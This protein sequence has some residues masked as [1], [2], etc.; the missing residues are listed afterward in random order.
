MSIDYIVKVRS[1]LTLNL[2]QHP[3]P[4]CMKLNYRRYAYTVTQSP[5]VETDLY[6]QLGVHDRILWLDA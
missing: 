6:E 1:R 3:Y 2:A 4:F 5:G